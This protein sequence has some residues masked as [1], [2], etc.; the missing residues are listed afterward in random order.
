MKNKKPLILVTNDDGISAPGIRTL[1]DVMATIGEVIVVAPDKPQSAMGH[2]IT[3]NNTLYLDKISKENDTI[4]EYSC[5]GTPVDCVKLAVNEILKRKPDLCVSGIN[6]GSNSSINVIY[7]GT[8][9]AAVEAGIEGIPAIGFSLLDYNWNADFEPAKTFVKKIVLETLEKKLP[10]G[11]ILNVNFPKLKEKEIKGIKICRQAKALW[12]EKF[13]KRQT[14]FGK[15]YYWLSGEF[16]NQDKGDDTD[17]W[18]LENGYI[19]V[20]PVQFDLTAHHAIQQL[21]T[22]ALNE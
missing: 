10:H 13:D 3:I 6:H 19:S 11:V 17:E 2:A 16:V 1:I 14:P 20:V 4:T 18:A 7:S 21:N 22:W 12:V 8:M 15:D 5:S 9:S